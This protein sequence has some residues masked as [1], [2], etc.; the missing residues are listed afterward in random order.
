M[1][2]I[3]LAYA[4]KAN[5]QPRP[6]SQG[7][8]PHVA[9]ILMASR[10][11]NPRQGLVGGLYFGDGF[12]FQCLEGESDK[13]H[14]LFN[15]LRD[16]ERHREVTLLMEEPIKRRSFIDWSMKYVP[17]DAEVNHLLE[18]AGMERFNPFVFDG[19]L[20]QSMIDMLRDGREGLPGTERKSGSFERFGLVLA[21]AVIVVGA[22]ASAAILW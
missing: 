4:S 22:L 1:A 18:Q 19:A 17:I 13:V 12:F 3:R 2:L 10:R 20:V 11:N 15:R 9:R 14:E 16:D 8:E 5:F 6:D 7:V 21:G